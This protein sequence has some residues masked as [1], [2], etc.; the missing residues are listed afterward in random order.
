MIFCLLCAGGGCHC[1]GV[2][3]IRISRS[4]ADVPAAEWVPWPTYRC[5]PCTRGSGNDHHPWL[6]CV[7]CQ[8]VLFVVT[9]PAVLT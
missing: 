2:C 6:C 7:K 3:A 9:E 4:T 8:F 1:R 5:Y